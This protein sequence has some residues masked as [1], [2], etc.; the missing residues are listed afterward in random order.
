LTLALHLAGLP[1]PL[2][3]NLIYVFSILG[4]AVGAYLLGR[5][6]F[7]P[8]AGLVAAVAYACAPYQLLDALV[9]GN[10]PESAALA[11]FP[12]ILWA[13]RR[14]A[15]GGGRR[16]LL[17]STGLLAALYLSHNISALLFTP[18]LVVYLGLVGWAWRVNVAKV[19]WVALA[20]GLA[21]AVTAFL[22]LPALAEK[23]YVQLEMSR[24]TR[25]NDFHYNFLSLAEVLAPPAA[26]DTSLM[27]PPMTV[28][29]GLAQVVL[30]AAGLVIGLWSKGAREQ[31]SGGA[32]EQG[33]LT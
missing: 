26:L 22:W 2:A 8:E 10:A 1:L 9:R 28:H 29:L 3:L 17:A 25:N 16:W 7:G 5:D 31:G 6:L 12:F 20:L 32:G 21:L 19:R 15:L 18:F 27:N 11:L 33:S 4:C 14:L 23:G 24:H 13:F 30:A